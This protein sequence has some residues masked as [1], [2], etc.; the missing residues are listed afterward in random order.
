MELI[1]QSIA[2]L[3]SQLGEAS[4]DISIAKFV[5]LHGKLP[6]GTK[7]HEASFWSPSQACFLRECLVLDSA[8][9]PVVDE[10]NVKLHQHNRS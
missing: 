7:L 3:F 9:A 1:K 4:D 2:S 8:W 5:E 6:G 10:L